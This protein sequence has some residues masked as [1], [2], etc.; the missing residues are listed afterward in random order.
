V[1]IGEGLE[2]DS[3]GCQ[4]HQNACGAEDL[5]GFRVQSF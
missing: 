1:A 4:D 3:G 2:Q 5:P